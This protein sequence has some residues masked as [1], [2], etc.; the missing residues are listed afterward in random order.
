MAA[1]VAAAARGR[2]RGDPRGTS[3]EGVE[4]VITYEVN[5]FTGCHGI[6]PNEK[7]GRFRPPRLAGV[8]FLPD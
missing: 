8:I 5:F 3:F 7:R 4:P 1:A 2:G 6:L